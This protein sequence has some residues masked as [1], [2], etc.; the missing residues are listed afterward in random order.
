[1]T[2]DWDGWTFKCSTSQAFDALDLLD[3]DHVEP[4]IDVYAE[5]RAR[6]VLTLR[7]VAELVVRRYM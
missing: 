7:I 6:A 3:G 4:V 5:T 2:G 1:V